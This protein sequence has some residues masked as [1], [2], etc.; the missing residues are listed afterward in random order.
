MATTPKTLPDQDALIEKAIESATGKHRVLASYDYED[1]FSACK[2]ALAAQPL[3]VAAIPEGWKLVPLEPTE[4][5]CEMALWAALNDETGREIVMKAIE[6]APEPQAVQQD[7][8]EALRQVLDEGLRLVEGHE[9]VSKTTQAYN[10]AEKA[11]SAI[12]L[13][14][15]GGDAA[16]QGALTPDERAMDMVLKQRD[17]YHDVADDLAAQ[18]ASITGEVIGEHSSSN[19]PWQNAANSVTEYLASPPPAPQREPL[20]EE[21][22]HHGYLNAEELG[23]NSGFHGGVRWA[24]AAH[25]IKE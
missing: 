14:L 11:R 2:A 5:M 22:I 17:Y 12:A 25:G 21:Q 15:V 7:R 13:S 8:G 23:V 10:W 3:A 16:A 24:E 20:T 1:V 19:N 9:L 4:A 18:I 6:A